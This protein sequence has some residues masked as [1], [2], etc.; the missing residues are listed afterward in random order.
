M[1][2][3]VTPWPTAR[4]APLSMNFPSKNTGVGCHAFPPPGNLPD[5]G[6][7]TR[8]PV[9]QADSLPSEPPEK[10]QEVCFVVIIMGTQS[11]A[12]N[13]HSLETLK[14]VTFPLLEPRPLRTQRQPCWSPEAGAAF[15]IGCTKSVPHSSWALS[16]TL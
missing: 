6:I 1:S 11:L 4:Q 9:L 16:H 15:S 12:F 8:S 5:P 7:K 2:N 14:R 13:L 10:P 3:S